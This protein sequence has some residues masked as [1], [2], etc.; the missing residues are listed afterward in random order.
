MIIDAH[1]HLGCML[2][3]GIRVEDKEV[4][5]E[6][7]RASI[8]KLCVS[9]LSVNFIEGNRHVLKAM[10]DYPTKILGYA[11]VNPQYGDE[12]V[13]EL[14]TCVRNYGMIGVK[15]HC[16]LGGYYIDSPIVFPVLERAVDL[17]VPLLIHASGLNEII[18]LADFFPEAKI[19]LAHMGAI[20]CFNGDW[21][22][23]ILLAKKRDNLIL[24]TTG[25]TV[26]AGMIETAVK[27]VGP[28]RIVFGTDVPLLNPFVQIAKVRTARISEDD[29]E[30]ILGENMAKIIH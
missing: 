17:D 16:N 7:S 2:D 12:A 4:V 22:N 5:D 3:H 21:I 20:P 1:A 19:I 11:Y 28:E 9:V 10:K 14:E 25:S 29:K 13:K 23:T 8:D 15:L 26:D 18:S 27:I 30:L 6:E 24:D